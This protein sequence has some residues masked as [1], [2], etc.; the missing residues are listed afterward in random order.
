MILKKRSPCSK[1]MYGSAGTRQR[2]QLISN[3]W[4]QTVDEMVMNQEYEKLGL[5]FTA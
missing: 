4:E 2:E 5:Q 3:V 1:R